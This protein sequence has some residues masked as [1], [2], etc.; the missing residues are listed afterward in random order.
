[1]GLVVF[2][3]AGVHHPTSDGA[4][5][6]S[7]EA[8]HGQAA[9][10]WVR[11]VWFGVCGLVCCSIRSPDPS[12]VFQ[13]L[14][15][16]VNSLLVAQS[17]SVV[18]YAAA[19]FIV[20]GGETLYVEVRETMPQ[21]FPIGLFASVVVFQLGTTAT[22]VSQ[23]VMREAPFSSHRDAS[24]MQLSI[25]LDLLMDLEVSLVMVPVFWVLYFALKKKIAVFIAMHDQET[26]RREAQSRRRT[27]EQ[28]SKQNHQSPLPLLVPSRR[29]NV[30][31]A[32]LSK[33][34]RLT[35]MATVLSL[36]TVLMSI[37]RLSISLRG[38]VEEA[39]IHGWSPDS[40]SPFGLLPF[41]F[42]MISFVCL[43]WYVWMDSSSWLNFKKGH[44]SYIPFWST[45]WHGVSPADTNTVHQQEEEQQQQQQQQQ[46]QPI[47]P[48]TGQSGKR[49]TLTLDVNGQQRF[50]RH[51]LEPLGVSHLNKALALEDRP[52]SHIFSRPCWNDARSLYS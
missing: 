51:S 29:K 2:G 3:V 8:H 44:V 43:A 31:S 41:S 23:S 12:G 38:Q 52:L 19:T 28:E 46:I 10:A 17:T 6:A 49:A 27:I 30:F 9:P 39:E 21:A 32:A 35:W 36:A 15:P 11:C 47:H 4:I 5:H 26:E 25:V 48:T 14:S 34:S 42:H 40:Y 50:N 7:K 24:I 22:L 18:M 16:G 37:H 33:L 45:L 1:M 20:A 13:R